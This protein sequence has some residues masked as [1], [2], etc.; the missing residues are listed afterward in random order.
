[1]KDEFDFIKLI[2]GIV[3]AITAFAIM[4]AY[5]TDPATKESIAKAQAEAK[6]LETEGRFFMPDIN[7]GKGAIIVDRETGVCYYW[8]KSMNAG[9]MTVLVDADGKPVIWEGNY[10]D[11]K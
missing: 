10:E 9:G 1:M 7:T 3:L 2:M 5:A 4:I 6:Q 8:R 11:E